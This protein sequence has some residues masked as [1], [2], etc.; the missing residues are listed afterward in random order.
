MKKWNIVLKKGNIIFFKNI[1]WYKIENQ[2]YTLNVMENDELKCNLKKWYNKT[3]YDRKA[4]IEY[5][6]KQYNNIR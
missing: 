2:K 6:K 5:S 4:K 1:R 3:W